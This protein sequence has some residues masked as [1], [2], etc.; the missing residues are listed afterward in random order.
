[1]AGKRK[2]T[3]KQLAATKR[4][5]K[6]PVATTPMAVDIAK[7]KFLKL[8]S[9]GRTPAVAAE[10]VKVTRAAFYKWRK[11]DEVFAAAWDDARE[12]GYDK[13]ED[14]LYQDG[15]EHLNENAR[16]ILQRRRFDRENAQ[17]PAA[18]MIVNVTLQEHVRK[19]IDVSLP[20]PQI[21][22]DYDIEDDEDNA[23]AN[24]A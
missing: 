10:K 14:A 11:D 22:T 24:I 1:M 16:Y 20:A 5:R 7:Q 6:K 2:Q 4:R 15:R 8:L 19:L 21:A 13:L 12:A 9:E 18:Q 17:P 3:P 23:P